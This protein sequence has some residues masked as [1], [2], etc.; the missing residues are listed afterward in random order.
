MEDPWK[1]VA[2]VAGE[3][4]EGQGFCGQD[5]GY[6]SGGFPAEIYIQN[7]QIAALALDELQGS[8]HRS[9]RADHFEASLYQM[10]RDIEGNERLILNQENA[11]GH[12]SP[13]CWVPL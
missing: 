10:I 9:R 1:L 3:R 8:R 6:R 4:D 2:G 7:G 11:L 13:L 5:I 12:V